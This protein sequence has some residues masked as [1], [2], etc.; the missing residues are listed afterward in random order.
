MENTFDNPSEGLR[1]SKRAFNKDLTSNGYEAKTASGEL[2]NLASDVEDVVK[3]V[4]DVSDADI[5]RVRGK[6]QNALASAK[7]S[8]N[9]GTAAAK[10]YAQ[11]AA[12]STDDYVRASP[13]QAIGIAALIGLSVGYLV[14]RR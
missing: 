2:K 13:W 1:S 14:S 4:A 7:E 9:N 11:D 3:R 10:Q 5:A 8:L 6:I 12:T